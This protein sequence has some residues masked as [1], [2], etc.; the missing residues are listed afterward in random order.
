MSEV[1]SLV[2]KF[3]TKIALDKNPYLETAH[4]INSMIQPPVVS[5]WNLWTVR[6]IT[7]G[8]AILFCQATNLL[9]LRITTNRFYF[10]KINKLGLINME[11]INMNTLG[12]LIF[13]GLAFS[14]RIFREVVWAGY[15]NQSGQIFLFCTK[16]LA[17]LF[18]AWV[19]WWVCVCHCVLLRWGD[20]MEDPTRPNTSKARMAAWMMNMCFLALALWVFVPVI[21][22]FFKVNSEYIMIANVGDATI[23]KLLRSASSYSPATYT[24]VRLLLELIPLQK[25]IPHLIKLGHYIRYGL[26]FYFISV[27]SLIL[28]WIPFLIVSNRKTVVEA[29][30]ELQESSV[31]LSQKVDDAYNYMRQQGKLV[32][33]HT[34]VVFITS[35]A[36][37]PGLLCAL[38]FTSHFFYL[39]PLWW[40]SLEIGLEL[41]IAILGNISLFLLYLLVS[42]QPPAHPVTETEGSAYPEKKTDS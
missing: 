28:T 3:V 7:V 23:R 25:N 10:F 19:V 22:V 33:W 41:P 38:S 35:A 6:C 2:L 37:L 29:K 8:F 5:Q 40:A 24:Q 30:F 13:S 20:S 39:D 1:H 34:T 21:W 4:L 32:A 14:D 36:H 11:V 17:A 12:Y 16:F 18:S 42:R 15:H 31:G 26:V 27:L 9:Y